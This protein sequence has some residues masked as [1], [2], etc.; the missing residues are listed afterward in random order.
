MPENGAEQ[1]FSSCRAPFSARPFTIL[2]LLLVVLFNEGEN[3]RRWGDFRRN[4]H[5]LVVR[6]FHLHCVHYS[7]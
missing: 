2:L 1:R 4:S 6:H 7:L 3:Q 5:V